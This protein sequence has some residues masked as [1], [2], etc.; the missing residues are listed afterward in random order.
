MITQLCRQIKGITS[1]IRELFREGG[2]P[3]TAQLVN[4]FTAVIQNFTCVY[5]VVDALGESLERDIILDLFLCIVGDKNLSRIQFLVTSRKE[6]DIE[7]ALSDV[8]RTP[9]CQIDTW[10]KIYTSTYSEVDSNTF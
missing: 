1:E 3:S 9:L 7:S 5:L 4:A 6:V 8:R 2:Q 10:K